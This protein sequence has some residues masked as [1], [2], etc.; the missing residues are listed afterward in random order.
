MA[1]RARC[2]VSSVAHKTPRRA[3]GHTRAITPEDSEK[4]VYCHDVIFPRLRNHLHLFIDATIVNP[5]YSSQTKDE[6]IT[7][8]K[9]YGRSWTVPDKFIKKLLQTEIIQSI[10]DWVQAKEQAALMADLRK[11]PHLVSEA[12]N[13]PFQHGAI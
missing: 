5:R 2:V 10:M 11:K 6:L 7:E 3:C 12:F 8:V 9:D 1:T 13:A 4:I